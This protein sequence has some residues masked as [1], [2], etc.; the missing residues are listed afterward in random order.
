VRFPREAAIL[1]SNVAHQDLPD[2]VADVL[3]RL[4]ASLADDLRAVYWHGSW[5]RGEAKPWSDHDMIIVLKR[6][7][8]DLLLKLQD[9]FRGRKAWSTFVRTEDELRQYPSEGRSQFHFGLV[10]L[11]GD[12][13]PP[14]LT[15][16]NIIDELRILALNI[17]FEA[18]YRLFHSEPLYEQMEPH[19]AGFQ[20]Q[21][22]ARMLRYAAKLAILAMK[23]RE[24][25]AG[26][27]YPISSADLR[28]HVTDPDDLS[29][30]DTVERWDEM[31][32][33][34]EADADP[35]A[36]RLDA[37]ARRLVASLEI[38]APSTSSFSLP[39]SSP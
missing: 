7:D 1:W 11:Y 13:E 31:K 37:F 26:R 19:Y 16:D 25:L 10:R 38:D 28:P 6:L 4:I 36:L 23:S 30:I 39:P 22:N 34:F 12:F 8:D 29:I 18:R 21:R 3:D 2:E 32:P 27:E 5:A 24:L 15:R 14:P 17:S 35:L 33:Q 9:I 20:R